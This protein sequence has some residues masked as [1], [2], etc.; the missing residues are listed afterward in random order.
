M[1]ATDSAKRGLPAGTVTLLFADVEGSTRLLHLLGERFAP[2]RARMRELVRTAAA[3]H[4]G[5]EVDW[6][7]DGVFLAF[8]R[9][10][11]AIAAAAE[12]QRSLA[13]EPWPADAAHRLRIG[14][15]TGEPELGDEGYVGMDV[16]V[17]AR[18]CSAAACRG[19]QHRL[20]L[21]A[22]RHDRRALDPG[23]VDI[24][25]RV[26]RDQAQLARS[27]ER[28]V[29]HTL[30]VEDRLRGEAALAVEPA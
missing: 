9:A 12:I 16:V 27:L 3:R 14:I 25:D 19:E 26:A 10:R 17:A 15:H 24:V 1:N 5:A 30:V 29:Q 11:D 6:A 13:A 20:L 18:V 7:G 4:D 2:S 22:E 8:S 21:R 28:D 23:W